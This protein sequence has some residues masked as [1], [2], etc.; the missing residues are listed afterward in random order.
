MQ[1]GVLKIQTRV[2]DIVER[3]YPNLATMAAAMG[4]SVSQV[5]RVREG[6]RGINQ[7]FI[8]GATLAFPEYSLNDLFYMDPGMEY[9]GHSYPQGDGYDVGIVNSQ[10]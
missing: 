4:I 3:K 10:K 2:F 1:G 7:K 6:S 9:G 5:Y 8:V